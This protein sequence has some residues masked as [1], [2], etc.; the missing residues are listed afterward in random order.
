MNNNN[1]YKYTC[2]IKD[3]GYE[4]GKYEQYI[5][6]HAE[7]KKTENEDYIPVGVQM[8]NDYKIIPGINV[9]VGMTGHGKSMLANSIAYRAVK[10][11]KNVCYITLE[12]SKENMFYQMLS[13][14]SYEDYYPGT[15]TISHTTI[16][17]RELTEK[18][19]E[20][21]FNELWPKFK[22]MDGNLYILSEWEFDVSTSGSL[23]NKLFEIEDYAKK[24]TGRGIDMLIVDY[25]QL[26]KQYKSTVPV[27]G[28]YTVLSR[29]VDDFRK[30]SLNYLGQN[31]Q[32]PI[33]LLSQLNRDAWNDDKNRYKAYAKNEEYK[34]DSTNKNND[35]AP[36]K[37]RK[38]VN[39][40]NVVISI[41]QIAGCTEIAKSADQIFAV[42][43]DE[44]CK[45]SKRCM[46]TVIKCRNGE[47]KMEP[48][49]AFM[50]PRYY[51]MGFN[52][53]N[54]VNY[55]DGTLMDLLTFSENEIIQDEKNLNNINDFNFDE[56][57]MKG[58]I[59]NEL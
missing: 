3:K 4:S 12:I 36:S 32:L 13:I 58:M 16:K 54:T 46:I 59:K 29:W 6:L 40:P 2:Q 35:Y 28:E 24:Q 10:N 22:N 43:S 1:E 14:K 18:Q 21:V 8:E 30:M 53:T 56:I 52:D 45:A 41:S 51:V 38:S 25:I 57:E 26:F 48:V 42:Y 55:Y 33:V 34:K 49:V 9:I 11:G 47:T 37:S 50:D 23:Q 19:E 27:Q 5:D 15:K 39:I 31:K 20:F 7:Y 17:N 44:L